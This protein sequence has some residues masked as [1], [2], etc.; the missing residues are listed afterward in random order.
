MSFLPIFNMNFYISAV[1]LF[2]LPFH[3]PYSVLKKGKTSASCMET[4]PNSFKISKKEDKL[5]RHAP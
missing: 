1:V 5:E 2:P 3:I 4:G